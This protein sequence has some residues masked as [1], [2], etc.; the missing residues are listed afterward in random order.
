[1]E[2]STAEGKKATLGAV[3]V[4]LGLPLQALLEFLTHSN[5]KA[6]TLA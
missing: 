2:V 5:A 3:L 1:M 4:E 6:R